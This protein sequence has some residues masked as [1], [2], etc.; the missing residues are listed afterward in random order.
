MGFDV[1]PAM[2]DIA[3]EREVE[4]DVCLK[5]LGQGLGLRP[6][7]FD[8]AIS[9][10]AL[11][12]LCNAETSRQNPRARL[13]CLFD[14]LYRCLARGARAVFQMYPEN[15]A[16]AEMITVTAMRSGF[17]GGIVVDYP[18]SAKAK[19]HYLCLMTASGGGLAQLP[20][21]I[22]AEGEQVSVTE[23]RRRG[24]GRRKGGGHVGMSSS[25]RH[26]QSKGR[27]WILKK[28]ELRRKRGYMDVPDD[29][30]YTGRKRRNMSRF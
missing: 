17:T 18:H 26:P 11:Q 21:A 16:Q 25:R 22:E 15:A 13:R 24:H 14:S 12:W 4:G 10:S 1:S 29:T 27:D 20:Q 3:V 5:D 6:G 28:K 19:K 30:K 8:G 2:L 7:V 9:I 23:R